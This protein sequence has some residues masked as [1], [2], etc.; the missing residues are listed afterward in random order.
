MKNDIGLVIFDKKHQLYFCGMKK[1]SNQLRQAQVFHSE[2]YL[3][4]AVIKFKD[5]LDDLMIRTVEISVV[6][7]K[8]CMIS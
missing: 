8:K 2:K 6:N 3:N 1:W 4:E 5:R 7:E